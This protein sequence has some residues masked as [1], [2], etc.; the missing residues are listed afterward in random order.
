MTRKICTILA[1]F[2]KWLDHHLPKTSEQGTI[3]KAIR[4]CLSHWNELNN[5]LK[6]GRIEIDNNLVENAIRPFALGRTNWMFN[7]SPSGAKAGATFFSLI[8]TCKANNV[9]P[10]QYFCA[11]LNCIRE[12]KTDEDYRELLPQFIKH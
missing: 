1:A 7:A 9:E 10:Y 4:Y 12:C 6:D 11:M 2:K 3:G 8:E 5:Y